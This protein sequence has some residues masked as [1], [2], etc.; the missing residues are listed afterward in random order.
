MS[1]GARY[2][3]IAAR[4]RLVNCKLSHKTYLDIVTAAGW[5]NEAVPRVSTILCTAYS[6]NILFKENYFALRFCPR[7]DR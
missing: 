5:S 3:K 6:I 4:C 7:P 1:S 2:R